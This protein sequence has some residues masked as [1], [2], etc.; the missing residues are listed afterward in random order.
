MPTQP[1]VLAIE[2]AHRAA[3]ARLGI[4]GAY[5]A[6]RDWNGVSTTAS[7]ATAD[8]W[9]TRNLQMLNGI[10]RKSARL[11]RAYYQLAR[12]I[13]TGYTLGL[14]EYSAD[15]EAITM[16]GL[17]KQFLDLMLEIA[18]LD[19]PGRGET[20]DP[21]E[22]W[23]EE[24]LRRKPD[25]AR[26]APTRDMNFTD[27]DLDP[28]IQD[29]LDA[30]SDIGDGEVIEVDEFEWPD[31]KDQDPREEFEKLIKPVLEAR[32]ETAG[33]IADS[34]EL[35]AREATAKLDKH[36]AATGSI[37][38]GELDQAGINAGRNV[39][40]YATSRDKRALMIARMTGPNP[41][42]FCSMLASRGFVY[43]SKQSAILS[44]N[45][46]QKYHPNCHCYAVT[47]WADIP[48]PTAPERTAYFE[49]KWKEEV[50]F[51]Y[52]RRGTKNDALNQW[53]RFIYAENRA[54]LNRIRRAVNDGT[55]V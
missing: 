38:G 4:A 52:E 23:L 49:K 17:R 9:L 27:T 51:K 55:I 50:G 13:E 53:R 24:E 34:E 11:A 28:Y 7:V 32:A 54:R 30:E 29:W 44:G 31:E 45:E 10:Q 48:D 20:K 21:D 41:C 36:H 40:D 37:L 3:Q 39:I 6:I 15:P 14:P 22:R 5:L 47:R 43:R 12:A 33:K 25:V 46:I 16:G 18:D 1:E 8:Q 2:E 26:N 19:K 35:S 42:A